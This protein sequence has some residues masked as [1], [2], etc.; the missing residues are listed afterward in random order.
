MKHKTNHLIAFICLIISVCLITIALN[1]ERYRN[2]IFLSGLNYALIG[3][4]LYLFTFREHILNTVIRLL[5]LLIVVMRYVVSI[6][7][8]LIQLLLMTTKSVKHFIFQKISTINQIKLFKSHHDDVENIENDQ[9]ISEHEAVRWWLT[10]LIIPNSLKS[11][12]ST[13]IVLLIISLMYYIAF[14]NVLNGYK[15]LEILNVFHIVD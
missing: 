6:T 7:H 10:T 3:T 9:I 2:I 5:G 4:I 1:I 11:W 15:G 14:Q 8:R 12:A 13:F